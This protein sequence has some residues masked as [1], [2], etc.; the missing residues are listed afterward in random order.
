MI[1]FMM[2]W[3][4]GAAHLSLRPAV[5]ALLAVLGLFA[6]ATPVSGATGYKTVLYS[7]DCNTPAG[8]AQMYTAYQVTGDNSTSCASFA[9]TTKNVA[10]SKVIK[11]SLAEIN[12]GI[13]GY[14]SASYVSSSDCQSGAANFR[15]KILAAPGACVP[16]PTDEKHFKAKVSSCTATA[17]TFTLHN[18]TSDPKCE[19]SG[20]LQTVTLGN[21]V[22][23]GNYYYDSRCILP[24][25]SSDSAAAAANALIIGLVVGLG[26]PLLLGI[27]GAH[28]Y[29]KIYT[30]KQAASLAIKPV[31]DAVAA[32]SGTSPAPGRSPSTAVAPLEMT[33][34]APAP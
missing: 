32:V 13:I 11:Y 7:S 24:P 19:T 18:A 5:P 20:T 14:S 29:F 15:T 17:I 4:C 28:Y 12:T 27:A 23:S 3:A 9:A 26:A 10:Y 8:Y 1:V 31:S 16:F 25:S 30:A 33:G 21:C 22:Q 6:R 2:I 34:V